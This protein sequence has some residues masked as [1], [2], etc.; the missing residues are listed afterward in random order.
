MHF[1]AQGLP[2]PV[3]PPNP[4]MLIQG[5][6]PY[7]PPFVVPVNGSPEL[8]G[9]APMVT[10]FLL[11]ELNQ[12]AGKNE[13]RSFFFNLASDNGY[14]NQFLQQLI[15]ATADLAEY[16]IL[17]QRLQPEQAVRMAAGDVCSTMVAVVAQ[18]FHAGLQQYITP[19][20]ANDLNA[21]LQK[22]H[23]IQQMLQ[24]F[25][26]PQPQMNYGGFQQ[27]M[28]VGGYNT[29]YGARGP[30]GYPPG[31]FH[32]GAATTAGPR[33]GGGMGGGYSPRPGAMPVHGA[34]GGYNPNMQRGQVVGGDMWRMGGPAFANPETETA[35]V[36]MGMGRRRAGP[37]VDEVG[38]APNGQDLNNPQPRHHVP[39]MAEPAPEPAAPAQ[40]AQVSWGL[41][42]GNNGVRTVAPVAVV[43]EENIFAQLPTRAEP[44]SQYVSLSSD[45]EWPKVAD[46]LRPYDEMLLE[47]GSVVRPALTSGWKATLSAEQPYPLVYD[48]NKFVLFHVR[49][50]DGTITE[51]LNERKDDMSYLDN[52]LDPAL[53]AQARERQAQG[54]TEVVEPVWKLADKMRPLQAKS[55]VV[56]PVDPEPVDDGAEVEAPTPAVVDGIAIAHS[57]AEAQIK[58][59][60]IAGKDKRVDLST[61]PIEY[62][63]DLISTVNT[64]QNHSYTVRSL[65]S[66]NNF[67]VLKTKLLEVQDQLGDVVFKAIDGRLTAAINEAMEKNLSLE[68]WKI[69]TFVG[70][71]EE[72]IGALNNTCGSYMTDALKDNARAI[73]G[74][75]LAVLA[76]DS[77]KRYLK[78]VDA[79]E[80]EELAGTTFLLFRDRCSVTQVPWTLADLSLVIGEGGMIPETQMPEL[81][82][83]V[84][85]I[86]ER[87]PDEPVVFARRFLLTSDRQRLEIRKGFLGQNSYLLYPAE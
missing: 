6:L 31:G 68:G 74:S 28:P 46:P 17:Q 51:I 7:Q 75:S 56:A 62:Y 66:L 9:L 43:E 4:A 57:L 78:E 49:R 59:Q 12:Q 79:E 81:H 24:Q 52:E 32:R 3:V 2:V 84:A 76:G 73:I 26:N 10:G 40:N 15:Q 44:S 27:P 42:S 36:G 30:G 70:D 67:E 85:E 60:L 45:H 58:A 34:P 61:M 11:L 20:Q 29:G 82:K 23:Q 80:S 39:I 33:I 13:L 47:D 87:T 21:L 83:A 64:T 77:Y 71:Y 5:G 22:H 16:Y 35:R 55:S 38:F 53:R 41:P 50:P 37:V 54:R 63:F 8:Q 72:L 14:Q 1:Q 19:Q 86:F 48:Y 69:D 25:H 65:D 18:Q